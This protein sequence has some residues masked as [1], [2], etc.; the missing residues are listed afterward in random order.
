[1]APTHTGFVCPAGDAVAFGRAFVTLF[2]QP[3]RRI[4]M[5]LR[6]R[7]YAV[8]RDWPRSLIP[9]HSAWRSAAGELVSTVESLDSPSRTSLVLSEESRS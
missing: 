8:A 3:A 5:G 6:A 4:E 2:T 1:M 7:E 9:L